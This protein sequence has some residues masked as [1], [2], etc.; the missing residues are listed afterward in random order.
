MP[1]SRVLGSSP[2]SIELRL[3]SRTTHVPPFRLSLLLFQLSA[4]AVDDRGL[5]S[6]A[7]R[8]AGAAK[9][10]DLL[11]NLHGGIVGNLAEDDVLAIEP[12][13]H[14]GGDEELRAV[15]EGDVRKIC[16]GLRT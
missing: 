3:L 8:A 2:S 14:N 1:A 9:S 7:D 12:G 13:G 4:A 16:P 11:D 10:L 15:A 6:R 5:D